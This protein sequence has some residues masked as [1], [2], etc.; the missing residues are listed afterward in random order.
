MYKNAKV[1]NILI[2]RKVNLDIKDII[3][4]ITNLKGKSVR[5]HINKGRRKI[6]KYTG[7]I[8]H[9]Y[10][11]IFTVRLDS[12]SNQNYLSYSYSEVL[13]GAVKIKQDENKNKNVEG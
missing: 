8:E 11:S 5:M 1:G 7:I 13:C 6:E 2:M 12:N 9:I 3:E 4:T 10:P